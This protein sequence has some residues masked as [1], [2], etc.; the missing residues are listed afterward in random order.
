MDVQKIDRLDVGTEAP[1]F[2]GPTQYGTP[3]SLSDYRGQ[4]VALYFYPKDDSPG[5]TKQACN[6]RDGSKDLARAGVKVLG[7][8]DDDEAS[9][10]DFAD[11]YDLPFPLVADTDRDILSRYGVYGERSM[12]G[13]TFMG[14]KR[15]TY[16]IDPDGVIRHVFKAPKTGNHT[17]EILRKLEAVRGE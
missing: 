2:T 4:W 8:S 12:Y 11:D 6:L 7:V 1:D 9:H 3:L 16:L 13:N 17:E 15:T 5:C 14:T 10:R